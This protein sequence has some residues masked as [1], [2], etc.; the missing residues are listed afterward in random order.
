MWI[1]K[2]PKEIKKNK[3]IPCKKVLDKREVLIT[4][5]V[6]SNNPFI[7]TYKIGGKVKCVFIIQEMR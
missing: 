2:D 3:K 5:F 6:K 7:N 1:G 4:P